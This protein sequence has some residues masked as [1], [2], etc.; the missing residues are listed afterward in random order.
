MKTNRY[1]LRLAV[2][3]AAVLVFLVGSFAYADDIYVSSYSSGNGTIYKYDSSG[4]RTT[5][6]SGL[7][8]PWGLA[9]DKNGNLYSTNFSN[10]TIYKFDSSGSRSAFVSGATDCTALTFDRSGNL[11][12]TCNIDGGVVYKFDSNKNR[13]TFVSGLGENPQGI[14]FDSS[15]NFYVVTG[16]SGSG[17]IV[18]LDSSGNRTTFASDISYPLG[19]MFDSITSSLYATSWANIATFDLN[20]NKTASISVGGGW[21]YGIAFDSSRNLFVADCYNGMIYK[22]DPSG[23]SSLF[24]SGLDTPYSIVVIPEPLTLSLLVFGGLSLLGRRNQKQS[25]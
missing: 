2:L 15:N 4:N 5:F 13:S 22:Y 8:C 23:N 19:L 9:A 25:A 3:T 16:G 6:A 21:P 17:A 24:A 12:A 20:G 18:K 14:A 1:S 10:D 7:F 11:Y